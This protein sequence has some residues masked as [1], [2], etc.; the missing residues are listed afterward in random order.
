MSSCRKGSCTKISLAAI[1]MSLKI[2]SNPLFSRNSFEFP[3]VVP[4]PIISGKKI[5]FVF[6][7]ITLQN[8]GT[9][10][11]VTLTSSINRYLT[12]LNVVVSNPLRIKSCPYKAFSSRTVN[13]L[14]PRKPRST[15]AF[16]H[17]FSTLPVSISIIYLQLV[18]VHIEI[19]LLTFISKISAG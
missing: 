8:S 19:S 2:I 11:E 13:F 12:L 3:S 14:C 1:P 4:T 18:L 9:I 5:R 16:L 6:M 10:V 15:V 7:W 17:I